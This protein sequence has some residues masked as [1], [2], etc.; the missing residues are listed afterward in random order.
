MMGSLMFMGGWTIIFWIIIVG[1]IVWGVVA[2]TR[3][4]GYGN[5]IRENKSPLCVAQE[6]YAKGEISKEEFE[7]LKK[8][9][10]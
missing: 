8:D 2:L 5:N 3:R 7:R 9:L 6:R 1:L 10:N 4:R